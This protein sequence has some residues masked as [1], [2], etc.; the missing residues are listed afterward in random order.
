M[1]QRILACAISISV[2]ISAPTIARAIGLSESTDSPPPD[3]VHIADTKKEQV[4]KS[5]SVR[6][7]IYLYQKARPTKAFWDELAQCETGQ[8]W[9]DSGKYA[10][11]LGIYVGT[12]VR[13]GGR[14]F[15]K[16]PSGATREEQIIVANRIAVDGYQ[17]KNSYLTLDDKLNNKPHF[18]RPV[19]LG[20]WGCYKSKSTGKYRMEKPRMYYSKN[21]FLV[22]HAKF[23]FGEKGRIVKDLQ[24]F[25]RV[26]VDGEYG[27]KTR[28]A[29]LR[30]LVKNGHSTEGVPDLPLD[31]AS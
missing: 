29:H 26:T 7:S 17:T 28:R 15:A 1:R 8:N 23:T 25:L 12:W 5:Q 6:E 21:P 11:G 14:E 16:H 27:P 4:D 10:G 24:T 3:K 19:G 31:T 18:Q 22:P 2:F 20:G 13:Y 30:W 9:K